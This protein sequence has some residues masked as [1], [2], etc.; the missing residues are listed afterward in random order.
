MQIG[1][2]VM[3]TMISAS[4]CHSIGGSEIGDYCNTHINKQKQGPKGENKEEENEIE[5]RNEREQREK[6]EREE[7]RDRE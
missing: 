4:T 5:R 3:V 1:R 6:K 7:E 2:V